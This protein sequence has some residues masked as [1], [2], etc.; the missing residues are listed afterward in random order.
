[1]EKSRRY[2]EEP[3]K[4]TKLYEKDKIIPRKP[5]LNLKMTRLD[6]KGVI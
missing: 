1:M 4:R 3:H 2:E 6:Q 5:D